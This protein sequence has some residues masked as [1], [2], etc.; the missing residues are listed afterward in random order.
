MMLDTAQKDLNNKEIKDSKIIEVDDYLVLISSLLQKKISLNSNIAVALDIKHLKND[1]QNLTEVRN[2]YLS[3]SNFISKIE[4]PDRIHNK[5]IQYSI[6]L[7]DNFTLTV[8]LDCK[9]NASEIEQVIKIR[10]ENKVINYL[11][12]ELNSYFKIIVPFKKSKIKENR[13]NKRDH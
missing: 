12:S 4:I 3:L 10:H 13:Y 11:Y 1:R 5:I 6:S 2:V 7:K 9:L 8:H